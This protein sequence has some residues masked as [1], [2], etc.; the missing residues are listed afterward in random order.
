MSSYEPLTGCLKWMKRTL[1]AVKG[2]PNV[3]DLS[4]SLDVVDAALKDSIRTMSSFD[5]YKIEVFSGNLDWTPMHKD[6]VFWRDNSA[7]F[8]ENDY[9]VPVLSRCSF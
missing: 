9:Q 7:K 3:Q 8:E 5:K 4:Q 6:P 2:R 1:I